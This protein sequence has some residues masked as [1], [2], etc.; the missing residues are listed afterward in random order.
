M[1]GPGTE[2][3]KLRQDCYLAK[4]EKKKKQQ[5]TQAGE[6]EVMVSLVVVSHPHGI[7]LQPEQGVLRGIRRPAYGLLGP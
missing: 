6:R 5:G 1:R 2:N 3:N 4:K 7:Q